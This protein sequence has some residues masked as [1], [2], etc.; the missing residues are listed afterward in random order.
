[1]VKEIKTVVAFVYTCVLGAGK[2]QGLTG[3]GHETQLVI[4]MFHILIEVWVT[5]M[6]AFVKAH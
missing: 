5:P 3:K 4:K 1:M 6:K 2:G